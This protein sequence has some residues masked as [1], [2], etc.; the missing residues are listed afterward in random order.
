M[1][2]VTALP[3]TYLIDRTGRIA[4]TYVGVVDWQD[5]ETNV[6]ALLAER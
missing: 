4:A 1:F 2:N 5:I 6:K 3:S